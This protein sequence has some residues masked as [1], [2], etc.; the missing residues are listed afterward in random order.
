MSDEREVVK[1]P[2]GSVTITFP[3][4]MKEEIQK[5]LHAQDYV[6]TLQEFDHLLR[7]IV[8]HGSPTVCLEGETKKFR[9]DIRTVQYLRDRLWEELRDNS[10]DLSDL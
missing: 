4:E 10:V 6:S 3:A 8:K 7:G 5:A 2:C 9:L 1:Y